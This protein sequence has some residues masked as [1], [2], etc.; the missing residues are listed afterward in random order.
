MQRA[1]RSFLRGSFFIGGKSQFVAPVERMIYLR[2]DIPF[3]YDICYADDI[4]Y[5]YQRVKKVAIVKMQVL[6]IGVDLQMK[7]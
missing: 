2:Y 7:S 6:A 4:R 3:G 5:A 1:S